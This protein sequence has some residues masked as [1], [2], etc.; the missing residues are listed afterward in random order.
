M[1]LGMSASMAEL[2]KYMSEEEHDHWL[3]M[4]GIAFADNITSKTFLSQLSNL[5]KAIGEPERYGDNYLGAMLGSFVPGAVGQYARARDPVVRDTDPDKNL[6]GLAYA[7]DDFSKDL[8]ARIPGQRE[9]LPPK[10]DALGKPIKTTDAPGYIN[11]FRVSDTSKADPVAK[12][13]AA[14]RART[15]PAKD[16]I[17]GVRLTPDEKEVYAKASG[18]VTRARLEALFASPAYQARPTWLKD[19]EI[20]KVVDKSRANVRDAIIKGVPT[21]R[22]VEAKVRQLRR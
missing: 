10:Y 4:A 5:I 13:M 3:K 9:K 20:K 1:L 14:A 19:E 17:R 6:E 7:W 12:E 16:M 22:R 15:S 18:T 2:S 8:Q 11:P 21:D